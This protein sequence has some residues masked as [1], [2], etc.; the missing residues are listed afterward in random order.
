MSVCTCARDCFTRVTEDSVNV[1]LR[2]ARKCYFVFST[3]FEGYLCLFFFFTQHSILEQ[4]RNFRALCLLAIHFK[5]NDF[6]L[7]AEIV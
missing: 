6:L 2:K 7:P 3:V 5:N 1:F 4:V